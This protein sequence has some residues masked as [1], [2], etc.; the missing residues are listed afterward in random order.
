MA[1]ASAT[2]KHKDQPDE[3]AEEAAKL[4]WLIMLDGSRVQGSLP[5]L[6]DIQLPV[7]KTKSHTIRWLWAVGYTVQQISN[8]LGIK[9]QM[10]RNIAYSEPKRAAREDLGSLDVRLKPTLTNLELLGGAVDLDSD[11]GLEIMVG[12]ALDGALEASLMA[13]RKARV[14]AAAKIKRESGIDPLDEAD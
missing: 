11:I 4:V 10:V 3:A 14:K 9:Y 8:G 5:L 7:S 6:K 2:S 12:E 13:G 1:T